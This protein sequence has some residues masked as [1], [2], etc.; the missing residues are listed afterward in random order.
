[1]KLRNDEQLMV[2]SPNGGGVFL[3]A[4]GQ[5][6][7]LS[8]VDT[9]GIAQ[10]PS[11]LL[12][13]RQSDGGNRVRRISAAHWNS[14]ILH[15]GPLDLHDL[16]WHGGFIYA[17]STECNSVLKLDESLHEIERWTLSDISDSLHLNSICFLDGRL[18]AS[19][20]GRFEQHR[21]YKN[22]TR[23]AGQ[24]LDVLSGN[25]LMTGLSQPHSL[26]VQ[27]GRLWLCDSEA[28]RLRVFENGKQ[29][30]EVDLSGYVRGLA[31]GREDIYVGLSLSRNDASAEGGSASIVV[32]DRATLV[33][34][35]SIDIPAK[36]IYDVC[37]LEGDTT[38]LNDAARAEAI[39]EVEWLMGQRAVA[40]AQSRTRDAWA[41]QLD[42]ELHTLRQQ[43]AQTVGHHDETVAWAKSI[44]RDLARSNAALLSTQAAHGDTVEWAKSL[45]SDLQSSNAALAQAQ[46]AHAEAITWAQS[47]QAEIDIDRENFRTLQIDHA[48]KSAW[49]LR[50]NAEVQSLRQHATLREAY[51]L[52][53]RQRVEAVLASRSWRITRPLRWFTSRMRGTNE[54]VTLPFEHRVTPA[55]PESSNDDSAVLEGLAFPV[56]DKPVVSIVIPTYGKLDYTASCLHSIIA[57]GAA[58]SIEVLV[59]EDASGEVDMQHLRAIPGLRYHENP[60]N[61]GFLL[62]CNQ[63]LTMAKG[64]YVCFLNN[65]T[66]VT[67]GWLDALLDVILRFPDCGMVGSKLVYPDGR[68]QEAGGIVWADAS[69]WNFGRLD[70]P[71]R[72]AYNYV[73]EADYISG[74]SLLLRTDTFRALGGFDE[75]YV[76]AYCEDTD[77][78]F[79]I[80]AMGQKVY[81]Q[82]AS[83]VVHH[84]GVSHGTDTGSGIKA[85]QVANQQKF[86]ERWAEELRRAHF[87]NAE[88]VFLARDRSQLKKTVLVIDHYVPQ[89]DRDAGSRAMSQLMGVLQ[90]QGMSVKFWPQNLHYDPVYAPLLQQ[91]GIEVF[92]G[93]QY[94]GHFEEWIADNGKYLDY[95]V[96]SRPHISV[97]FID[98]VR[99]HTAAKVIYYGHDIHHLRLREQMKVDADPAV[100]AE[101][102][103]YQKLEEQMWSRSDLILY[104]ADSETDVVREWLLRND[105]KALAETIPLYAYDSVADAPAA[106]LHERRDLLFVAGF[107]HTPNADGAA[108]F[109]R[110]VLP[111]VRQAYPDIHLYLVGSHPNG[112]V[113]DLAGP[114]ITVTGYVSDEA[115]A[116]FY[117][118]ARVVVAPLRYGGGMK[119][120]VLEA[121]RFGVPCVTSEAGAQGLADAREFLVAI[122][123]AD[124]FARQVA[125]LLHD[126]DRWGS[127]SSQAQEFIAE[128]FSAAAVW[129]V[130]SASFDPVP[131]ANVATRRLSIEHR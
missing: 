78:A 105:R 104:P 103:R 120:K 118:R 115:L 59:L 22:A 77:L 114:G 33:R 110:E 65:D 69:A 27:D 10:T 47:L 87:A 23:G 63:A 95:V 84:E 36:E 28:H 58:A 43:H 21:G 1:M 3:L 89:P 119:G 4:D 101:A 111:K 53:L 37:V 71:A 34:R 94:A 68:L 19:I 26:K 49:A 64:E 42:S 16:L 123:D 40:D 100:V 81:L 116:N 74:A 15:D 72:P 82:P 14:S 122:D 129:S 128:R 12:W 8:H 44:E 17:V 29:A 80:R 107:A 56:V 5:V 30:E 45:E 75:W 126:D 83:V 86:R 79:R 24:V 7:R 112:T 130:L 46:A 73:H 124:D 6:Q 117:K 88:H 41:L 50:L 39:A 31:F 55:L 52:D 76:P 108:W 102:E 109:V 60:V 13:A 20:F 18:V 113:L 91:Q 99:R 85:Y 131:Y 66:V 57:A 98:A 11:G 48:E 25:V 90:R 9:T 121:M 38:R 67:P 127:V 54:S 97:E 51:A 70:D 106:N 2:S 93:H 32:L 62:S 61:L 96:L 125:D 92:H 35:G